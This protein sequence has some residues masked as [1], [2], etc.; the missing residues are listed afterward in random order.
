[1]QT[2]KRKLIKAKVLI[3]VNSP[4]VHLCKSTY[5]SASGG[6]EKTQLL[7][8]GLRKYCITIHMLWIQ[9]DQKCGCLSC[10]WAQ[11]SGDWSG[12]GSIPHWQEKHL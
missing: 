8:L 7:L 2:M 1:M 9:C 5:T 3:T 10:W 12:G 11:A 6:Q 4:H